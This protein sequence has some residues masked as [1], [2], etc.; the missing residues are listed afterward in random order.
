MIARHN[1][2]TP[3]N[4]MK[5]LIINQPLI[6]IDSVI[7]LAIKVPSSVNTPEVQVAS[8]N[9]ISNAHTVCIFINLFIV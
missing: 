4:P 9:S 3:F 8:V 7:R 2:D 6:M 5:S 1:N